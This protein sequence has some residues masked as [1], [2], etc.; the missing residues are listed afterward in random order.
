MQGPAQI[1]Q[2]LGKEFALQ[3]K[4]LHVRDKAVTAIS[5]CSVSVGALVEFSTRAGIGLARRCTRG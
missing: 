4:H 1:A 2:V 3:I 5:G